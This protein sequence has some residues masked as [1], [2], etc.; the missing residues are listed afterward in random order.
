MLAQMAFA[1][2]PSLC[3]KL[4]L[5][6][7]ACSIRLLMLSR[8]GSGRPTSRCASFRFAEL[9]CVWAQVAFAS[10]PSLRFDLRLLGGNVLNLA[11]VDRWL[12]DVFCSLLEPYTLPDKASY[13]PL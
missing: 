3:S 12:R 6:G 5:L 2:I 9:V 11:F 4:R 10:I 1:S 7:A 13:P 8:A